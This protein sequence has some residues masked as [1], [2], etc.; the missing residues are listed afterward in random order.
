[1][2]RGTTPFSGRRRP[3][4]VGALLR[5]VRVTDI[6]R[7]KGYQ[8]TAFNG[9]D[10]NRPDHYPNA[11]SESWFRLARRLPE[12]DLDGDDQLAAD[13]TSPVYKLDSDGRRVVE[14]R[15]TPRNDSAGPRTVRTP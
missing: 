1:M 15:T 7:E 11:R 10:R 6:L 12:L 13:L 5:P 2:R 4:L 3:P 8:V 9:G 14:K